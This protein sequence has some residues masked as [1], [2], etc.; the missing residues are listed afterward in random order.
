MLNSAEVIPK[1]GGTADGW[2]R[3]KQVF[4]WGV[5]LLDW[6]SCPNNQES[7]LEETGYMFINNVKE[8]EYLMKLEKLVGDRFRERPSDDMTDSHALMVRGG[9]MKYVANG[10]YFSYFA[11]AP[12]YT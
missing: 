12:Y 7:F 1:L 8:E 6:K 10:I 3:P 11:A 2:I 5:F 4:A 9:Y